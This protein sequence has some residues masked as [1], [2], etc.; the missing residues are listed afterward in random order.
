MIGRALIRRGDNVY[1]LDTSDGLTII[2]GQTHSVDGH[3][4]PA[5]WQYDISLPGPATTH[6][7]L[8]G[9]ENVLHM[10]YATD[11]QTPWRGK[12]A[13]RFGNRRVDAWPPK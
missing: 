6:S 3:Y 5:T 8:T 9:A 7:V 10:R 12:F 4:M 2:P 13:V 11:P 1:Y